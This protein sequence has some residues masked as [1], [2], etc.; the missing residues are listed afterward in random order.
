VPVVSAPSVA[1]LVDEMRVLGGSGYPFAFGVLA[2]AC[3]DTHRD[4]DDL[5]LLAAN[6]HAAIELLRVER[7]DYFTSTPDGAA[8]HA[9]L[10]AEDPLGGAS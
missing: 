4:R 5:R 1:E 2:R 6:L 9:R 10:L 7:E 8:A 3:E